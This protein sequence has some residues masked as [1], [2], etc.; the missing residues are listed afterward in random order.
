M[1]PLTGR[2]R[3]ALTALVKRHQSTLRA[4][5]C[6]FEADPD[7]ADEL[8][9]DAFLGIVGKCEELAAQ[10]DD[11]VASYLR[12]VARNLVRLRWR[13]LA[14][15]K[16]HAVDALLHRVL[17][18]ALDQE[19]GDTA[20]RVKWLR[21]CLGQL[22][23][24]AQE[25]VNRHFFEGVPLAHIARAQDQSDAAARMAMFR[26]VRQLRGCVEGHLQGGTA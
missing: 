19:P 17:E 11:A 9:Q 3:E 21:D 26:I 4:F 25:L 24:Q 13:R 8:V 15:D 6:R 5:L 10:P 14:T 22:G 7:V 2:Q 1:T 12:G 20:E 16:R 23:V 18:P